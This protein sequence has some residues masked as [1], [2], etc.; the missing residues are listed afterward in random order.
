MK[1]SDLT[2]SEIGDLPVYEPGRPIELVAREKGI[3]LDQICKLASNE[4]P[5][6]CSPRAVS[7]VREHAANLALYPDNSGHE[8]VQ[9]LSRMWGFPPHHFALGAGSNEIFYLL[10]DLFAGPG[11]EVV[12]GEFA[13]ISYRIAALLAGAAPV[14]VSMPGLRHDLDAMREAITERTRLLFLPNPNNP[15]GTILP[16]AEILAFARSL[17]EHVILCLDEAYTEYEEETEEPGLE[18]LVREDRPVVLTRTFS[19]IHGLAGLRIGYALTT[20]D[21]ASLLNRVRSPFNT[22]SLAQA[23]A[24]AALEDGEWIR[25]SRETNHKGRGQLEQGLRR[26]GFSLKSE[27][28]NFLLIH[29]QQAG[30]LAHSLQERG[31]IT[32]PLSGYGLADHLRITIGSPEQNERLL[33]ELGSLVQSLPPGKETAHSL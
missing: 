24:V 1:A 27:A 21:L 33:A 8:L 32:R 13:F 5:L 14:P 2:R 30:S 18:E 29:T 31:L 19:K 28:G 17:P 10:C 22:G 15:T 23:A 4:N 16:R 25:H 3:P 7:A 12:V 11:R 26:L 9:Q 6:G 20:P